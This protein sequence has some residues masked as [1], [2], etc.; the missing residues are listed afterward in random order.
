M[1]T[2]EFMI[3]YDLDKYLVFVCFEIRKG[4]YGLPQ[5]DRIANDQLVQHLAKSGYAPTKHTPVF[6]VQKDAQ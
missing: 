2:E 5:V 6:W 4:M 3:Q 1:I